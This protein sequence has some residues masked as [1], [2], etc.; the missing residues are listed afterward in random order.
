MGMLATIERKA[1]EVASRLFRIGDQGLYRYFLGGMESYSGKPVTV[2]SAL[3]LAAVWACVRLISETVA[4]LPLGVYA[5]DS[6]GSKTPAQDHDL[7]FLLHDQPN[8]DMTAVEFWEAMV[9][10]VLLYGNAYAEIVRNPLGQVVSLVPMPPDRVM[11]RRRDDGSVSYIYSDPFGKAADLNESQVFHIKGF[12]VNGLFGLSPIAYARHSFGAAQATDE[13]S[14]KIFANGMRPSGY[15]KTE[16]VLTPEQRGRAQ[17]LIEAFKGSHNLGKVPLLEAGWTYQ[18]LSI[19]P[20]DAQM[21]QTRGFQV[22]EICRWFRVPPWMIGH[23]SNSTSWGTGLEQQMLGFLTYTLRPYLA[24]IE[25]TVRKCLLPPQERGRVY[26]E[27]NCE[28]LLRADSAGRAD[29]AE[30]PDDPQ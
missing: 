27:F 9:A 11:V 3:Q 22:E 29:D 1:A 6:F 25:M 2:D 12:S 17:G 18:Q 10:C 30:R 14:A 28:G 26:A 21:L 16:A 23:T 4:T 20:E 24:R 5:T 19:P 15:M 7:Y 13:A 8:G